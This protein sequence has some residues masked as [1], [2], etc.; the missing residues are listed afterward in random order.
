M[1]DVSEGVRV[2]SQGALIHP[3]IRSCVIKTAEKFENI[4]RF[5]IVD[6]PGHSAGDPFGMVK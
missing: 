6:V 1:E 4:W 3:S 5:R 2:P